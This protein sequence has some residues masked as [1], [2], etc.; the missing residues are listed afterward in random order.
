MAVSGFLVGEKEDKYRGLG[1]GLRRAALLL[2]ENGGVLL[3]HHPAI[4]GRFLTLS[5]TRSIHSSSDVN[6]LPL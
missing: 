4:S 3:V 5:V 6:L 1:E 2:E